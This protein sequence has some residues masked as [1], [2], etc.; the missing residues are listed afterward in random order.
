MEMIKSI[1]GCVFILIVIDELIHFIWLF[2]LINKSGEAIA[3]CFLK[4]CTNF[5][6]PRCIKTDN[7]KKFHNSFVKA[8]RLCGNV[9]YNT[10][11]AHNHHANSIAKCIICNARF[12]VLKLARKAIGNVKT[13]DKFVDVAALYMNAKIHSTPCVT[14]FSFMFGRNPFF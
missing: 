11:I 7:D 13:W 9:T 2:V 6:F 12:V 4:V 3:A 10:T 8:V 14:P 5:G 1:S